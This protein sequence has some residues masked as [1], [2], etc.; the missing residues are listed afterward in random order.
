[1]RWAM[2]NTTRLAACQRKSP[3]AVF[4]WHQRP[5]CSLIEP[6]NPGIKIA[7]KLGNGA[8]KLPAEGTAVTLVRQHLVEMPAN[9]VRL[10]LRCK[11]PK[12][13]ASGLAAVVYTVRPGTG[14][15]G[16]AYCVAL[17]AQEK[18]DCN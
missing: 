6:C 2:S 17:F 13:I 1:M 11:G 9:A 18:I 12:G 3:S 10:R 4:P 5:F 7:Q 16:Y 15:G 14:I 8:I